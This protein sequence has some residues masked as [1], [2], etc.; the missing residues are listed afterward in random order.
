MLRVRGKSG[1]VCHVGRGRNL[2]RKR[3][4]SCQTHASS[5]SAANLIDGGRRGSRRHDGFSISSLTGFACCRHRR[6]S[7]S[8]FVRCFDG[9]F[10]CSMSW[11]SLDT[12]RS[13]I[14]PRV[15]QWTGSCQPLPEVRVP[16]S[17]TPATAA[18]ASRAATRGFVPPPGGNRASGSLKD[19]PSVA[20]HARASGATAMC[21]FATAQLSPRFQSMRGQ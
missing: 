4:N 21:P 20:R 18:I 16:S 1:R 19:A 15:T 7:S 13:C 6:P 12:A 10:S 2:P 9:A 11:V 17:Q 3:P 14:R 5:T 8:T